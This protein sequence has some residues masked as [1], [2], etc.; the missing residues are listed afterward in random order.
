MRSAVKRCSLGN[1]RL[2]DMR[3]A[4][5]S[6]LIAA[7]VSGKVV[8]LRLGHTSSMVT[9]GVYGHLWPDSDDKT[10]AAVDAFL[11]APADSVRPG[12]R[13]P[14]Q[15]VTRIIAGL[16]R[17]R[18]LRTPQGAATRPTTDRVREA[19]FSSLDARLG[20]L[21]GLRFL[22]VYAGSGAVGLEARSR[23]A[24]AVVLIEADRSTAAL[25]KDNARALDIGKVLVLS[26]RAERFAAEPAPDGPFD[27]AFFDPPYSMPSARVQQLITDMLAAS[28]F[29]GGGVLVVER[30]RRD[31]GWQWPELIHAV[32]SKRYGE[33][34]L[35]YGRVA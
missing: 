25:I 22:D 28:W 34:V 12:Q 11:G 27:V 35:W 20:S 15:V 3:H 33:T 7:G 31:E 21:E 1:L 18:R 16:A 17:G 5:A 4:Y 8:Q 29:S 13:L 23:G 2:H 6:A 24:S 30:P 10:R 26:G 19:L 32:Q 14:L 9:L